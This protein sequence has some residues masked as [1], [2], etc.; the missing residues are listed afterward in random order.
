MCARNIAAALAVLMAAVAQAQVP[1]LINYQG[2]LLDGTNLVN[3]NV[4]LL[5][6]LYDT[7]TLG[8]LL[9]E[10]SNSTVNVSDGLYSTYLGDQT[11]FGSLASALTNREVWLQIRVNGYVLTPRERIAAVA[12]ALTAS[13]VSTGA[14]TS[15][16]IADG[17]VTGAKISDGAVSGSDIADGTISNADIASG[18]VNSSSIADGQVSA[19]DV[20]ASSF[21]NTFWKIDGNAGTTPGT[22]YLGTSDS[23]ALVLA[24]NGRRV[25]YASPAD[26]TRIILG[27]PSNAV[28]VLSTHAVIGG[29][30]DA[31]NRNIIA[32]SDSTTI[33]GGISNTVNS[34]DGGTIAGGAFNTIAPIS[35]GG[36]P[37][38]AT[39]SGGR[40]N[41]VGG[42]DSA[43]GGGR[44]NIILS[45]AGMTIG[46]GLGN[47]AGGNYDTVGGGRFNTASNQSATIAGGEYNSADATYGTVGGGRLNLVS[48]QAGTIAG[49]EANAVTGSY[50]AVAGGQSNTAAG[51]WASVGGGAGNTASGYG[52]GVGGGRG[53]IADGIYAAVGGGEGNYAGGSDSTIPG[54]NSNVATGTYS[55]AAGV[56]A[57]AGHFGTFVWNDNASGWFRST[58]SGQFA[59]HAS[60]GFWTGVA[61][62]DAKAVAFGDRYEDNTV[63]A[64]AKVPKSGTL[65]A[66]ESFNV[67]SVTN[68]AEGRYDI[69]LRSAA[70]SSGELIP[71]ATPEIDTQPT[72][73]ATVRFVAIDQ[74]TTNRFQVYINNGSFA[75]T[76]NDFSF[77]VT[78]RR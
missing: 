66:N 45:G 52:A 17:A 50:G 74:V 10:D 13:G 78:G 19:A 14:I 58:T 55:F 30:G 6:R 53:N 57:M 32:N 4:E 23:N 40:S 59:V 36:V 62:G 11:T 41:L 3:G 5:L 46:G 44:F 15:A 18:A 2:R 43:V 61:A 71:V 24:V 7:N 67:Q 20:Q 56:S 9:Y 16:M 34:A 76:N 65:L 48:N 54:G 47:V 64:W 77:I 72:S 35:G 22:H 69:V 28:D 68:S 12:Y 21:S 63:V 29:G 75:P 27:H 60:N 51:S 25:F 49:G 26:A 42:Q 1:A 33:G 73:A 39:I 8:L 31:S 37:L 38:Y 70:S